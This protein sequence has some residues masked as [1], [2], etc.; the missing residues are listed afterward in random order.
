MRG[1]GFDCV[2]IIVS[3]RVFQQPASSRLWSR[4]ANSSKPVLTDGYGT[5]PLPE[6]RRSTCRASPGRQTLTYPRPSNLRYPPLAHHPNGAAVRRYAGGWVRVGACGRG[7][8]PA[9]GRF[10][11]TAESRRLRR[12]LPLKNRRLRK[13]ACVGYYGPC[14]RSSLE[15]EAGQPV[16]RKRG[17][18]S[19]IA[20][21]GAPRGVRMV[22]QP[23]RAASW[24][25]G[26]GSR[27]T[28]LAAL[29]QPLFSKR[30]RASAGGFP[31]ARHSR[32]ERCADPR[33]SG[34]IW[35]RRPAPIP[36]EMLGSGPGMTLRAVLSGRHR[37]QK[38]RTL[39]KL[40]PTR[41]GRQ[42]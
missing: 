4:S 36:H 7:L 6:C 1:V 31:F 12:R 11:G 3:A 10:R 29:R 38:S 30:P 23:V 26:C 8:R 34:R 25:N 33:I 37:W 35:L 20:E 15:E 9:P 5:A 2:V 42:R 21:G 41:T 28:R 13:L 40:G 27:L 32:A 22:A 19:E 24:L 18:E 16:T 17:P 14:A 39:S